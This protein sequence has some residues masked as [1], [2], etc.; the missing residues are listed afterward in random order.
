[1]GGK[2]GVAGAFCL[3]LQHR[4]RLVVELRQISDARLCMP[5][6]PNAAQRST[7]AVLTACLRSVPAAPFG[8]PPNSSPLPSS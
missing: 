4:P 7:R 2:A 3:V 5:H 1:M 6:L 8:A